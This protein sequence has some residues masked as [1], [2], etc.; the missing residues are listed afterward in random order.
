M[1]INIAGGRVSTLTSMKLYFTP[2]TRATRPRWLLEELG[3]PYELVRVDL[4][5]GQNRTADYLALH[6]LAQVPVL[7]DDDQVLI[8]SAAICMHL[9]DRFPA[10]RLAPA[11]GSRLRGPYLQWMFYCAA[12]LEP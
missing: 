8:E 10:A 7:V 5:A 12:T 1:G 2:R 4:E 3:V 6:P 9:G 11:V